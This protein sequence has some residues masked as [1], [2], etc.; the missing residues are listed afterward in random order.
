MNAPGLAAA[1]LVLAGLLLV[2]AGLGARRRRIPARTRSL[3]RSAPAGGAL[4]PNERRVGAPPAWLGPRLAAAGAAADPGRVWSAW[5][6]ATLSAVGLALF[7]AGPGAAALV[8]A[9][10]CGGPALGWRLLRHRG[11]AQLDAALPAAI[12]SVAAGLR[13]GASLRQA[14]AEAAASTPGVL[15]ADLATVATATERGAGLVP[16][17]EAWAERRPLPGVRL[18]VAALS[19]GAETGGA[20]ARA[21]DAVAATLRQRLAAQAEAHALAT[22]AR[23]SAAVIAAA[24]LAFCALSAATDPRAATFLLRTPAGLGLLAAGLALDAA[25]ALWMAR[26][27]R[28]V[29]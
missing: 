8:L 7:G 11:T 14:L 21:V 16:A 19:L 4:L 17:L 27:T 28:T 23:V 26:I 5:T 13:S 1:A 6:A 22:Q 10:A 12:E 24:P 18:A 25:G 15:G 20:T 3:R 29:A 9:A 2:R